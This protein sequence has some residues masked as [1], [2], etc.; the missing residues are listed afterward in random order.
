MKA[1]KQYVTGES[2]L[3][4]L[5]EYSDNVT[6]VAVMY[7]AFSMNEHKMIC[8]VGRGQ[9]R[10]HPQDFPDQAI[11]NSLAFARALEDLASQLRDRLDQFYGLGKLY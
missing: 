3:K 1:R 7:R 9:A 8:L 11:G 2:D 4:A 6:E 5:F 10:R